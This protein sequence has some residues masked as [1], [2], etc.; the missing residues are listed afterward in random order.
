[1]D[2]ISIKHGLKKIWAPQETIPENTFILF[3]YSYEDITTAFDGDR[4]EMIVNDGNFATL[5]LLRERG[6]W[7]IIESIERSTYNKELKNR[8]EHFSV[9]VVDEN[10]LNLF[11]EV[12]ALNGEV[13]QKGFNVEVAIYDSENSI[14]YQTSLSKY[15]GEFKGFEVFNF[16][17][18]RLDIPVDEIS[19]IRIY[20]TR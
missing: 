20:P 3:D 13:P 6:Q 10:S 17:T 1:M 4:I 8:I 16:G 19:K 12:L 2:Y 14:I 7:I 11:C 18:I 9:K 15:D 5:R